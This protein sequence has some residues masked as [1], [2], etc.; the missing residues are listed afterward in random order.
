MKGM[1]TNIR[2]CLYDA[3]KILMKH[4]KKK[5]VKEKD[6]LLIVTYTST[7]QCDSV[8][9]EVMNKQNTF[10]FREKKGKIFL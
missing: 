6:K 2:V 4:C 3:C 7:S 1:N 5:N 9:L 10:Q 8:K